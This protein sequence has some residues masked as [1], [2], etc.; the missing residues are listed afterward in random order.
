MADW[1]KLTKSLLLADG[2][3]DERE[4]GLL[5]KELFADGKIDNDEIEFLLDLRRSAPG[6]APGFS[7]LCFDAMKS[8]ILVDGVIDASEAAWLKRWILADGKVDADEKKF[9]QDL[10]QSARQVS[11]EF[12]AFFAQAMGA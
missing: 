3:L 5:R 8:H 11:K 12:D 1:R 4:A 10:K 6:S 9:L 2:K 7:R